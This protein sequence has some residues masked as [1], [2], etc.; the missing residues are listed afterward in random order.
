MPEAVHIVSDMKVPRVLLV[1]ALPLLAGVP[2]TRGEAAVA[3]PGSPAPQASLA[4]T[5]T[6]VGAIET[7]LLLAA[8]TIRPEALRAA[9]S[10]W[11]VL[12]S[13]GEISRPLLTVIDYGLPS[14]TKRV[15]VFD[16]AS[17][18]LLFHELVAH[19]R[20]SGEDLARS[21]S[22]EEGSLMTSLGAFVTG[23]AYNGRNGYSLRLRGMEPGV[24]DR[25]EERAIVVHGASYVCEEV[26]HELGRL[27]RSYGCP[28]VRPAIARTLID[29]VK[30][31][32]LLYA[33]HPSMDKP[34]APAGAAPTIAALGVPDVRAYR[35]R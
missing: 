22:N 23:A 7:A 25:A 31:R 20:N 6:N 16:L 21:F 8:P 29:E 1:A 26:A 17:R 2:P 24:N 27:G 18:R 33:W 32:T 28:A 12:H 35:G 3:H 15:W 9:L 4:P 10:A 11:D 13:R 5:V 19:G 14:T 30:G 34:E